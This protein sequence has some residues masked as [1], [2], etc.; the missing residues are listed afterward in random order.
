MK[1]V[2]FNDCSLYFLEKTF[3][4][5]PME[6]LTT[7]S[8]W[9]SSEIALIPDD[10]RMVERLNKSLSAN[11]LHWN[12]QE[13][14]LHYIGP[15]FSLVNFTERLRF[16]IFAQ[17]TIENSIDNIYLTGKVDELIASGYRSPEIPFFAFNEYKKEQESKG[18]AAGQALAAMLVGQSLNQNG[19]PIYGSYIVGSIWRFMVL[20]GKHYAI[21]VAFDATV[22]E[23]ACQILRILFQLKAYCM[24]RTEVSK[25]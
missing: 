1:T 5:I 19:L 8:S 20:E 13:L 22:F 24:E 3:G 15:L 18:D 6:M 16:N 9:I 11:T 21:S 14:S 7:L 2:N 10:I 12:E 23:D 25:M 4:L 17:R